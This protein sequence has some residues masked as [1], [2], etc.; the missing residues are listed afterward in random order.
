[1]QPALD[2]LSLEA[3][4]VRAIVAH[5]IAAI[6]KTN[7]PLHRVDPRLE[8]TDLAEIVIAVAVL[9]GII[10]RRSGRRDDEGRSGHGK[11]KN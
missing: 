9:G 8:R 2:L 7:L 10:L 4:P 11:S 3:Q 6:E 5:D 1:V